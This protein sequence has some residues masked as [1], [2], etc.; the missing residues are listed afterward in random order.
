TLDLLNKPFQFSRYSFNLKASIG[1]S[2]YPNHAK[3]VFTLLK[4][5]DISMYEGK[6]E[7]GNTFKI[8][9]EE[10]LEKLNLES[11]LSLAIDNNE[12]EVYYQPIYDVKKDKIV[13]AEA[14][15]RWMSPSGI[16][17]PIKFI[18]IAKKNGDIVRIDE[19]VLKE[20][21]KYCNKIISL[22]EKDFKMSVNISHG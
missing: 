20:A 15:I 22:G 4:Y 19:F 12:F 8:F 16:I 18:P 5:A 3:D 1:I 17:P 2:N 13:G 9:S 7:G 11:R 10:M 21:C 6:E 14:L